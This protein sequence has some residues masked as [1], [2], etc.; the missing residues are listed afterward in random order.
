V[1]PFGWVAWSLVVACLVAAVAL[2]LRPKP[3][4]AAPGEPRVTVR[5]PLSYAGPGSLGGT[6]SALRR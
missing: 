5:G 6:D 1:G 2:A 3:A 4:P